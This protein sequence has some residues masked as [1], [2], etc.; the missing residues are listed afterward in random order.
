MHHE[1][2][3]RLSNLH[4]RYS[5]RAA[6]ALTINSGD[7]VCFRTPDVGWGLGPPT[8][9]TAARHKVEP[10]DPAVHDGPCLCGPVAV[11]GARAGDVLEIAIERLRPGAWGW[12]Y[13][14]AG[15]STP[16]L[17]AALGIGGAPL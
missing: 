17:N 14:G 7:T 6:P 8:S 3:L 15:L 1:L 12:T 11:R 10:R 2:E 13:A 4:A 16:R 5:A 9:A